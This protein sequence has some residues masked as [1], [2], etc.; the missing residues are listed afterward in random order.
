MKSE[1]TLINRTQAAELLAREYPKVSKGTW[2]TRLRNEEKGETL[3]VFDFEVVELPEKRCPMYNREDVLTKARL[4]IARNP[5][6]Y[7]G[8]AYEYKFGEASKNPF[9]WGARP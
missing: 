4:A 8:G 9:A 7:V 6:M 1:S 2:I 5:R 3:A